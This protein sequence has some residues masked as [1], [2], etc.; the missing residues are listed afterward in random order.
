M[1]DLSPN[2]LIGIIAG[3][4][5]VF[6]LAIAGWA[7]RRT[8]AKQDEEMKKMATTQKEFGAKMA[9]LLAEQ[10]VLGERLKTGFESVD[11]DIKNV[12]ATFSKDMEVMSDNLRKDMEVMSANHSR[13]VEVMSANI[14]KEF[15][16]LSGRFQQMKDAVGAHNETVDRQLAEIREWLKGDGSWPSRGKGNGTP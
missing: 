7:L 4:I 2:A 10:Q 3:P 14:D 12:R 9:D 1:L 6:I 5:L 8:F 11:S 15:L 16:V 13:V